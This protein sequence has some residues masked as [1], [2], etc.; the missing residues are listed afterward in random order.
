MLLN[1][2]SSASYPYNYNEQ[3]KKI[4]RSTR[5]SPCSYSIPYDWINATAHITNCVNILET[6][7][8]ILL[9][10]YLSSATYSSVIYYDHHE[11]YSQV[12][13]YITR[14]ISMQKFVIKGNLRRHDCS[15]IKTFLWKVYILSRLQW[16][17]NVLLKEAECFWN[18]SEFKA[19]HLKNIFTPELIIFVNPL[20]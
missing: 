13:I 1:Q 3:H 14:K 7:L 9:S 19:F 10:I 4:T 6:S 17:K 11:I 8:N 15:E 2:S 5:Y 16:S 18:Y 20:V 12:G